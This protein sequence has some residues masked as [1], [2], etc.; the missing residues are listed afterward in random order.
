VT[1]VGNGVRT[2]RRS[3][4]FRASARAPFEARAWARDAEIPLE[5]LHDTLLVLS[6][7]VTNSFRHVGPGAQQGIEV[8]LECREDAV[9]IEVRDGG[10]GISAAP[11]ERPTS[12][13]R[14]GR[15]LYLIQELSARWGAER[16]ATSCVWAELRP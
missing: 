8:T 2:T 13:Q 6:E 14:G 15:G 10:P 1:A 5:I 16:G 4:G 7:L 9:R 3:R 11:I 12:G